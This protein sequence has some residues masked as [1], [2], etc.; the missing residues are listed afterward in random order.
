MFYNLPTHISFSSLTSI[1]R[2]TPCGQFPD[3]LGALQYIQ[4]CFSPFPSASLGCSPPESR[5]SVT[6]CP[7]AFWLPE[8]SGS[9]LFLFS[10]SLWTNSFT[11]LWVRFLREQSRYLCLVSY[12]TQKLEM[13]SFYTIS[14]MPCV[15]TILLY[16]GKADR[17]WSLG[18]SSILR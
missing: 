7:S 4:C 14:F 11:V 3:L 10:L 9:W 2:T 1:S 6:T 16:F 5:K 12:P 18:P 13:K 17:K 8:H 15:L